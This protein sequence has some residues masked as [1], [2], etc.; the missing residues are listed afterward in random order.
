MKAVLICGIGQSHCLTASVVA[1]AAA[2]AGCQD[3]VIVEQQGP[4][5]PPVD[6][7]L[8]N[9][10]SEF[11]AILSAVHINVNAPGEKSDQPFYASL[12]KYRKR[13]P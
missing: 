6:S 3:L 8:K 4:P 9:Y 1:A 7:S 2:R 12:P 10:A 5:A 11:K 13:K